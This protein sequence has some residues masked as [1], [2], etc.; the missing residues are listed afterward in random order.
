[1]EIII[2]EHV[3]AS[4]LP[5]GSYVGEIISVT[6]ESRPGRFHKED[7]NAMRVTLRTPQGNHIEDLSLGGYQRELDEMGRPTFDDDGYPKYVK[8]EQ[9]NRIPDENNT[10]ECMAR[11]GGL[12][13]CAGLD[14]GKSTLQEIAEALHGKSVGFIMKYD[15]RKDRTKLEDFV[16]PSQVQAKKELSSQSIF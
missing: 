2:Q 4:G 8:D 16:K 6:K 10:A 5:A 12:A 11:I 13:F 1:M 14:K 3:S 15:K 9:D 7:I